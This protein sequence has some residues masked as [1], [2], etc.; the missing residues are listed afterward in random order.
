MIGTFIL[1]LVLNAPL[2]TI[3]EAPA[4][5]VEAKAEVKTQAADCSSGN[6]SVRSTYSYSSHERRGVFRGR[7]FS[8]ARKIF[9][10]RVRG[11]LRGRC[12]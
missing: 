6:C 7:L 8:G 12:G 10:G 11:L 9:K 2:D 3:P 1:S 4:V 5:K